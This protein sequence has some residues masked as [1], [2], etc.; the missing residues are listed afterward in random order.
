MR[1]KLL[2]LFL[3]FPCILLSENED[4]LDN[5]DLDSFFS[6]EE[7]EAVATEDK[8]FYVLDD[9]VNTTGFV[10]GADYQL[11]G[12][13]SPGAQDFEIYDD[14][15]ILGMRSTFSLDAQISSDFSV[16]QKWDVKYPDFELVMTQFY[17]ESIIK[18][19][20]FLRLGRENL[21]WG[22]AKVFKLSNLLVRT[23]ETFSG[24]RDSYSI[25]LNVPI[26]LGGVNIL[27]LTR[28]GMWK[29]STPSANEIG[30]GALYNHIINTEKLIFDL[31]LGLFHHREM[32]LRSFL[33]GKTTIFNTEIYS[34]LIFAYNM[35]GTDY[36]YDNNDIDNSQYDSLNME[37]DSVDN[38]TDLSINL[39]VYR[40]FFDGKLEVGSEYLFCGE[41]SELPDHVYKGHNI[42]FFIKGKFDSINMEA[43]SYFKAHLSDE[44]DDSFAF[45]PVVL[46]DLS[47]NLLFSLASPIILGTEESNFI[48][49]NID[50]LDREWSL[51]FRIIF[52]GNL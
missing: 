12:G 36:I 17:A 1:L 11:F 9:V 52:H 33:S 31:N 49:D 19:R 43:S 18:D 29:E 4:L 37:P 40:D 21:S 20:A 13:Y 3:L 41:E 8:E 5:E 22:E 23:P 38:K 30:L 45:S 25:R 28:E 35:Y 48:I 7:D 32:N 42:S 15:I 24:S 10:F 26:G 6:Q 46:W 44:E 16:F 50:I 51:V 34:E 14:A 27:A 2:Y 47:D 39:G